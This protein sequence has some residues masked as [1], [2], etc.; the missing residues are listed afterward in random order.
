MKFTATIQIDRATPRLSLN[1]LRLEFFDRDENTWSNFQTALE[2]RDRKL[3][4]IQADGSLTFTSQLKSNKY[5]NWLLSIEQYRIALPQTG[6]TTHRILALPQVKFSQ[7]AV[8]VSFGRVIFLGKKSGFPISDGDKETIAVGISAPQDD[9]LSQAFKDIAANPNIVVSLTDT[10]QSTKTKLATCAK[11]RDKAIK[12]RAEAIAS[13]TQV[14][15]QLATKT[16]EL[17]DATKNAAGQLDKIE[18]L[19]SKL[20]T[21]EYAL[22]E[23][24]SQLSES[25]LADTEKTNKMIALRKELILAQT[26]TVQLRGLNASMKEQLDK[27]VSSDTVLTN[28]SQNLQRAAAVAA[29]Q[30][31]NAYR[32][33]S[34]RIGLRA[35][36]SDGGNSMALPNVGTN[37]SQEIISD[38]DVE[39][40]PEPP[41]VGTT[42]DGSVP[43]LLGM[44]ETAAL[45]RLHAQRLKLEKAV[46]IL[47]PEQAAQHGR[48]IRQ[49]PAA[50]DTTNAVSGNKILV[51]FGQLESTT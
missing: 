20:A 36:L 29:E 41:E 50:G 46:R 26:E 28:L 48:V 22:T 10:V 9:A 37:L 35:I 27:P 42:G 40:L 51:V 18:A 30:S 31:G 33:G 43:N 24:L 11:A 21:H 44:T 45:Q 1:G 7:E 17:S 13:L 12:E 14:K 2:K 47:A 5:F 16:T 15:E 32:L 3:E 49:I 25:E 34:V 4:V 6:K 38:I 23:A 8:D 39:F 19:S